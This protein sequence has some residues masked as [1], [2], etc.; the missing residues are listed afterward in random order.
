MIWPSWAHPS[1]SYPRWTESNQFKSWSGWPTRQPPNGRSPNPPNRTQSAQIPQICCTRSRASTPPASPRRRAST[2]PVSPHRRGST[3]PSIPT[4]MLPPSGQPH[5]CAPT[6]RSTPPSCS[7]PPRLGFKR[8]G[9]QLW[10]KLVPKLHCT[11]WRAIPERLP[12]SI[13]PSALLVHASSQLL[14]RWEGTQVGI[15]EWCESRKEVSLLLQISGE[16]NLHRV[17]FEMS[18]FI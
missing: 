10:V 6:H 15:M 11:L 2:P 3:P 14:L 4:T 8:H 18:S 5:H 17:Q 9:N 1:A 13:S 16:F 12:N 7:K